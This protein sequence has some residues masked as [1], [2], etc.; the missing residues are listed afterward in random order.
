MRGPSFTYAS[1]TTKSST[2]TSEE[3][4]S[5][6]AIADRSTFSTTGAMRLL[7]ARRM[8]I[9]SPAFLSAD[10]IHHQP[11]LLR[12]DPNVSGFCFCFHGSLP[13]YAGFAAFS[14]AAFAEWPLNVRVGENSPSL[15]PTMFSVT[16][17]GM[18]FLPLCTAIV[19]P[20]NSGRIV[21]RRDQVRM[22]FFSFV[23]VSAC[24]LLDQ[25]RIG[26]RSFFS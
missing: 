20:T 1:E 3:R 15:W 7:V 12:R 2:S 14:V 11:R 4:F 23:S 22:T 26:E 8:L 25:V 24:H 10:Q 19:W 13:L 9:A 21:E 18:N 5:A 6:L 16:Y 17:T